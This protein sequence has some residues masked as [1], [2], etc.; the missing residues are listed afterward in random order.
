MHYEKQITRTPT[1]Y[2]LLA[3]YK[4]QI[5]YLL[6]E[7]YSAQE[8][9]EEKN[10]VTKDSV[11]IDKKYPH[12]DTPDKDK[13]KNII[14]EKYNSVISMLKES[15]H[16]NKDVYKTEVYKNNDDVVASNNILTTEN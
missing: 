4:S 8:K 13:H 16:S 3:S 6:S 12:K 2:Y 10:L 9:R 14:Q 5:D 11:N 7:I 15:A 1:I